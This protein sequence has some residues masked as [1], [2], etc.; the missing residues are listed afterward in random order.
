MQICYFTQMENENRIETDEALFSHIQKLLD[1]G[2]NEGEL[3]ISV[4]I[5]IIFNIQTGFVTAV[6]A[7]GAKTKTPGVETFFSPALS[8]PFTNPISNVISVMAKHALLIQLSQLNDSDINDIISKYHIIDQQTG[9]FLIKKDA[10]IINNTLTHLFNPKT[11]MTPTQQCI[12]GM[13]RDEKT[14]TH[15]KSMNEVTEIMAEIKNKI[16][17]KENKT[18]PPQRNP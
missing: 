7:I 15:I 17:I 9:K 2:K 13:T 8:K 4:G 10:S 14:V 1:D 6:E 18:A 12:F 11:K 5:K 16:S 3:Y